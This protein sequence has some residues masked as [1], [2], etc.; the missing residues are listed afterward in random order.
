MCLSSCRQVSLVCFLVVEVVLGLSSNLTVL[1]LYCIKQNLI[2]SVS[3]IIT[4]NL[5]VVDVLVSLFEQ[6]QSQARRAPTIWLH[7]RS[8]RQSFRPI[9]HHSIPQDLLFLL[10]LPSELEHSLCHN[11]L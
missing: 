7:S 10:I 8:G 9:Y 5:H 3:N 2:S 6:S 11:Y 4:M 1:I